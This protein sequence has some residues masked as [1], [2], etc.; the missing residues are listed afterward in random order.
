[1]F[2]C[3]CCFLNSRP[4]GPDTEGW[5]CRVKNPSCYHSVHTSP[6][7]PS[8]LCCNKR[9][10]ALTKLRPVWIFFSFFRVG[11]FVKSWCTTRPRGSQSHK[12]ETRWNCS[13]MKSSISGSFPSGLT[14]LLVCCPLLGL[15]QAASSS[16]GSDKGEV[17]LR[18][19]DPQRCMRHHF[20]ETITHPI[21]KCNSKV[22]AN[23][24][25]IQSVCVNVGW[26]YLAYNTA[27]SLAPF[28]CEINI[29]TINLITGKT[30]NSTAD[31]CGTV[32]Y[33]RFNS[34]ETHLFQK[35]W[36]FN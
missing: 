6:A 12:E 35:G 3:F 21:Y 1:M 31:T 25:T 27:I 32:H 22:R 30:C 17:Q 15:V 28:I 24:H 19:S 9:D 36:V 7:L 8:E 10:G 4:D 29:T 20:V 16:K 34:I 26:C 18:D 23:P 11:D 2:S 5:S 13:V 14:L 33:Y